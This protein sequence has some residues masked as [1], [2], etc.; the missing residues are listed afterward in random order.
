MA[1]TITLQRTINLAQQFIRNAPL[2][3]SGLIEVTPYNPG[4][5]YT[6]GDVVKIGNGFGATALVTSITGSGSVGPVQNLLLLSSGWNY[7]PG[8]SVSSTT[9]GTGNSLTLNTVGSNNDPAFSNA[10]WVM[11]TILAPPAA[12]R[13]NRAQDTPTSPTFT[14]VAGQTDYIVQIAD[15]GWLEKAVAYDPNNAYAAYELQVGLNIGQETLNNQP[16]RI[17]TQG[18]DGQGNITFRIF[19]APDVVYNVVTTYQMAAPQFASI[20][21][22]WDPIP[23]YL[24]Y[25]V[26]EGFKAKAFEFFGDPREQFSMQ[27]FYTSLAANL[28][29]LNESERNLWLQDRLA[30]VRQTNMVAQGKR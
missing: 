6:V 5:A 14:T 8:N 1:S 15:F 4:A 22:T 10:D 30:S 18:D 11:Q 24:S 9:G 12:W 19:P 17:T 2:V 21:Q 23:D 25:I 28:E 3:F 16:A 29:G 7:P 20:S 27:L 26:N 13:W